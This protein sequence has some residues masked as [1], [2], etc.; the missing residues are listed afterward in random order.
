MAPAPYKIIDNKKYMWAGQEYAN[1]G[2]ALQAADTYTKDKFELQLLQ[3]QDKH[4]V[5]T[6]R[7]AAATTPEN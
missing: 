2:E 5:Y 7:V 6:R 4:L 1:E 3:E